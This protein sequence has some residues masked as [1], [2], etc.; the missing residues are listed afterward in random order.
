[1]PS[2][3]TTENV[4]NRT[5]K[6]PPKTG[7]NAAPGGISRPQLALR[8]TRPRALDLVGVGTPPRFPPARLAAGPG[9]LHARHPLF[10][11]GGIISPALSSHP[12]ERCVAPPPVEAGTLEQTAESLARTRLWGLDCAAEVK[13]WRTAREACQLL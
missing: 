5:V 1:M 2:P 11:V 9:R 4:T 3:M 13:I 8:G 7:Q 12:D 10:K 6:A